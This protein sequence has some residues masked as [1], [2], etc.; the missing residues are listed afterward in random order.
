MARRSDS[1]PAPGPAQDRPADDMALDAPPQ[2]DPDQLV[3]SEDLG[4]V[5]DPHDG[6]LIHGAGWSSWSR[7]E[8]GTVVAAVLL[9]LILAAVAVALLLR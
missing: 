7:G 3:V 2:R 5:V 4:G 9:V 6:D 1:I 8:R